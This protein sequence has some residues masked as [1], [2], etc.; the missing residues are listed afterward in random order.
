V[1]SP[2]ALNYWIWDSQFTDNARGVTNEFGRGNFLVYRSLFRKSSVADITIY[3]TQYFSFRGNTSIGS[4]QFFHAIDAGQNAAP[5]TLQE[6]RILDTLNPVAIEVGN[7]GLLLLLDNEIRSRPG[8]SGPAVRMATWAQGGDLIS[9]GNVYTV[10]HPIAVQTSSARWWTQDDQVTE[11]NEISGSLPTLPGTLSIMNRAVFELRPGVSSAGMQEAI[12]RAAE[13]AGQRPVVHLAKG[14]YALDQTVSIPA[15][16][17]VQI[18]GDG[19]GTLL[20]WKGPAGGVMF[21]L[22][23]P[24]RATFRE[25]ALFAENATA[26]QIENPDQPRSRV[27]AEGLFQEFARQNNV[28]SERLQHTAINLQSHQMGHVAG[29]SVKAVGTGGSGTSRIAIFGATTGADGVGGNPLYEITDGGRI[30]VEDA[31][32]EGGSSRLIY[33]TDTG[34]FMANGMHVAPTSD[35]PLEPIL[36]LSGFSGQFAFVGVDF[37]FHGLDRRVQ[38]SSER[39]GGSA[40][41]LGLNFDGRESFARLSPTGNLYFAHNKRCGPPQPPAVNA[42]CY[43][44]PDQ[45]DQRSIPLVRSMLDPLRKTRPAIPMGL[46]RGTTD[47]RLY[48]LNIAR[49]DIGIHLRPAPAGGSPSLPK[50]S[51][52]NS[53]AGSR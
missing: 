8:V 7:L 4:R 29:V 45:G 41:F 47:V 32:Y 24:A 42:G 22:D 11:R 20:S 43:Q 36:N 44:V 27:H 23:G 2:N 53:S 14:N 18:V 34:T 26:I 31:W 35:A 40:F 13:L 51:R 6:N 39:N 48:R 37:D 5:I 16:A 1:E 28:L 38:V 9:V 25:L 46:P 15:N 33:A 19:Y 3:G 12:D 30:V 10:A 52:G 50:K 49:P 17:D 21:H